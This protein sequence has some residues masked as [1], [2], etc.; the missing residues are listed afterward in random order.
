MKLLR[1][2]GEF[3]CLEAAFNDGNIGHELG[4]RWEGV[5][6]G[7]VGKQ[8]ESHGAELRCH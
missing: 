8:A 4:L 5:G 7:N 1:L 2:Y 3:G 6:V